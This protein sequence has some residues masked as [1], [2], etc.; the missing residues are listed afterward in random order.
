MSFYDL[1]FTETEKR[2]RRIL[3]SSTNT[4]IYKKGNLIAGETAN[5][6]AQI[7]SDTETREAARGLVNDP[8]VTWRVVGTVLIETLIEIKK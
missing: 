1:A 2:S 5:I 6:L 4:K 3:I 7:N 8:D